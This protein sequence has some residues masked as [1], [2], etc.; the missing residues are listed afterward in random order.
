[1]A[2]AASIALPLDREVH[3]LA[4]RFP[5]ADFTVRDLIE[6]T[7][8]LPRLHVGMGLVPFRDPYLPTIGAPL[9]PNRVVRSGDR[10]RFAYSNLGY[11]LLGALL[12]DVDGD[13]FQT[14]RT[15]VLE[16]AG[17]TTATTAPRETAR[18]VPRR[19]GR[20]IKP[21]TMIGSPYA[22]AG[23][24]WSTFEDLCRYADWA[25]EDLDDPARTVAWRRRQETIWINGQVRA[26]GAAIVS[27][28]GVTAVVH[29]LAQR[30]F[31]PDR[32]ATAVIERELI[33]RGG[34]LR[35]HG[36]RQSEV[37]NSS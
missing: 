29:A 23:G 34:R 2:T 22:A 7:S 8:G 32:I 15:H 17:I 36:P 16:P 10:G 14:V 33:G 1:V 35:R 31:T 30:L 28:G 3:Q 27:A 5:G 20:P 19:L 12:D 25:L 6:H 13:W 11:A 24:V 21:W 37:T 26:A 9:D 4:P 18:V